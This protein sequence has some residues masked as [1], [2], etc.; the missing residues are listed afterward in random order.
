MI[1]GH[2]QPSILSSS[3]PAMGRAGFSQLPSWVPQASA[4]ATLERGAVDTSLTRYRRHSKAG[5]VV[6]AT[7][8]ARDGKVIVRVTASYANAPHAAPSELQLHWGMYRA[9]G[10]KWHHPKEAVPPDSTRLEQGGAGAMRTPMAWDG[11]AGPG[12]EG[13]WVLRF[14]V[15]A[16]LAPLHLAF[17]LYQPATDKYDV[18]VRAPH[19]AVPVGMSAGSPQPLGASVVAVSPP[20]PSNGGFN[21]FNGHHGGGSDPRETTCAVNFAVFSRHASSLQLC[22]VRL[23]GAEPEGGAGGPLVAQ[24]VLE[25][26]LDPLTNRTG[27][28]WHVCVHGLKDLETLCWAWRADGEI[29]WQNGN[30]FHPGFMLMDPHATRAVPVL[31]PPGAHKAAPRMAPSLDAG[32]PVLLGTLAAFVHAPFDWQGCHQAVRGGQSRVR[33]LEESVVVEVDVARFT[34]GRDAEA[35]VPPEHRGKYLGILDR[36]DS[37]KAAGAT[38]VLLSPVCLSAPGPSPAAG[39]SP[40]ALLAPDPAFAVGGPLA[41]AAELKAV[42]RG[43]HQAGLEVLLQVEFCV[44][45]EGG[46]AGAGRLQGLRG[47]DHAVYYRDGLEAPVLNCGHPVDK[48]GSV[49]DAPPLAEDI[50]GDPVLRGLKLVAAVSNP[51]LL[52]R[53]AERGF[54]HWG[55]WQQP[56]DHNHY[57][58]DRHDHTHNHRGMLSAVAT[59]LTGSADLFAP[60]WDAGLPGGLAAG[61]RAGFGLNAVAPLGDVPLGGVIDSENAMRGDALARS[62]LV[63]QFVSA[64]QPLLAAANLSRPG[65]PQLL[66]A[67]AA[68]RRGYRSLI[69][70]ASITAPEREV[71]WHSPY[72]GGE[73]DWSGSNP[74]PVANC[75]LLT[76]GGGASRPGHMLAAGFNPHGEPMSVSLPR[77]P[78]GAVWRLLVDTS[79]PVPTATAG[80]ASLGAVL[81]PSE[82]AQ[83]TLGPFGSV[84]L[85]A[86]PQAGSAAAVGGPVAAAAAPG[87]GLSPAAA[88]ARKH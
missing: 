82:Q 5:A 66:A 73:P 12:G 69:C 56:H 48:F 17:S 3:H 43:L 18:P 23:E 1:Q 31:L 30:R 10:T 71:A 6:D 51:A 80:G 44:T 55:V 63:A 58:H 16:K 32:E 72:G 46:D 47:L 20:G 76:L 4:T 14:E 81:P 62:L 50:A 11:R 49:L 42:I 60:R 70:P 9:S 85:D 74:D 68:V 33:A 21:G 28:V 39:R 37:L 7:C 87:Y 77:P 41:A 86:V 61:R 35:A 83:Y 22:L 34:T 88:A 84:L 75:V 2:V 27:D 26:V 67:L 13:A 64:G 15:P 78:A 36:L 8:E 57:R 52:P 38:T 65:V 40:L 24:S 45:A 79:R 19:F 53:L 59:R 25:V 29:L 54:P